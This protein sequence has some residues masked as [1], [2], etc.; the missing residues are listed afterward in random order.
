[1]VDSSKAALN[2]SPGKR[3]KIGGTWGSRGR[4]GE[5]RGTRTALGMSRESY[6]GID[7]AEEEA[8][9]GNVGSRHAMKSARHMSRQKRDARLPVISSA[10]PSHFRECVLI[11]GA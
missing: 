7:V 8:K 11:G 3:N 2:E 1:V 10:I 6:K 4:Q 5:R 9:L